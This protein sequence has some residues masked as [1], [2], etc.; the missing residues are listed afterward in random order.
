[1]SDSFELDREKHV[2]LNGR[3][4]EREQ[5]KEDHIRLISLINFAD[6]QIASMSA[7]LEVYKVG[8]DGHVQRLIEM[9]SDLEPVAEIG[10]EG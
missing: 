9:T 1:M 3:V 4:Y 10:E 2:V 5:L 8:R 6:Q 7:D